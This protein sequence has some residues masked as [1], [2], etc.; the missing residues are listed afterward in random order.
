MD[1]L[2]KS[3]NG[4]INAFFDDLVAELRRNTPVDTGRARRGWTKTTDKPGLAI[5]NQRI[6]VDNQVPYIIYLEEGSSKQAP[7]GIINKS[8]SNTLRKYY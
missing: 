1:N 2:K 4:D 8:I 3:I 5:S 7:N 6:V